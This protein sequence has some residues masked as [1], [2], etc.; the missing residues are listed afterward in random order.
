MIDKYTD[1]LDVIALFRA[2]QQSATAAGGRVIV[3]LGNH[4]AEF[5]AGSRKNKKRK[6]SND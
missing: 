6:E 1:S 2:L 3:T 4:E 5:L